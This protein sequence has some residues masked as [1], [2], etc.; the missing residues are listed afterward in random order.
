[1]QL[2]PIVHTALVTFVMC[3]LI[4]VTFELT[5]MRQI[6][7]LINQNYHI[8][9]HNRTDNLLNIFPRRSSYVMET[10]G[11]T[12]TVQ[13]HDIFC[14]HPQAANLEVVYLTLALVNTAAYFIMVLEKIVILNIIIFNAAV[15]KISS[16]IP[17]ATRILLF[18]MQKNLDPL[19]SKEIVVLTKKDTKAIPV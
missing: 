9:I 1:M 4:D 5:T 13:I 2:L 8:P 17:L 6:M 11:P 7:G 12:G 10:Y 14:V 3:S 18:F 19:L 16:E 15:T